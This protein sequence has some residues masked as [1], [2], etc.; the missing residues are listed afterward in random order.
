M[1]LFAN[2]KAKAA[3]AQPLV[4]KIVADVAKRLGHLTNA[5]AASRDIDLTLGI[6]PMPHQQVV[7]EAVEEGFSSLLVADEMG[8]GKTL[9]GIG[10]LEVKGAFPAL[11]VV[12]P[13][14]VINWQREFTRALPHRS[15]AAISGTTVGTVP[16]TDIV[17]VP[18]SVISAWTMTQEPG[19]RHPRANGPLGTHPWAALLVDEAHRL[20][21]EKAQRSKAVVG[22]S[23]R[24]QPGA[25]R[26]MLTGTPMMNRPNE[27][28]PLLAALGVL[29]PLF[30]SR[31]QF[32]NR[33]CETDG[34]GNVIGARNA[35]ELHRKLT[36]SVMIRRLRE[37][38]L[39]LPPKNRRIAPVEMSGEHAGRY[40]KAEDNL[41]SFLRDRNG[42]E[43]NLSDRA[44]A[45]VL[46]NTLRGVAGD[47][48]VAAAAALAESL[49]ANGE[50]VFIAAIHKNVVNGLWKALQKHGVVS[51]VGGMTA[52]AKQE[53]VDAF[54]SGKARVLVGNIDAAGVGLTLTAARHIIV[55]ELPWTPGALQQVEDR[56]HRIGQTRPVTSTLLTAQWA[57]GSVD[58]RLWSLIQT[59]ASTIGAIID[60]DDSELSVEGADSITDQLLASYR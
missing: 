21:N 51:I 49:L 16:G 35:G 13:S 25:L 46:L 44:H 36:E 59:K 42:D 15:V 10:A 26:I 47:G 40:R 4:Q 30:G 6:D 53:A 34:Y 20:K 1:S 12:P 45:I 9:S 27:L 22:I 39:H 57:K 32:L 43:Y 50:Q 18:D 11:V 54:Q 14:L 60:G 41:V 52:E 38:V 7:Y 31:A 8:V 2:V 19:E 48:K 28:V 37:Q 56:L 3:T 24:L 58:E 17:I 29:R 5:P 33:Y 23:N 55:A